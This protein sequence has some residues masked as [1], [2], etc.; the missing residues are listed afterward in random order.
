MGGTLIQIHVYL[1]TYIY[2]YICGYPYIR[3]TIDINMYTY[4]CIGISVYRRTPIYS[5]SLP[6]S[7]RVTEVT[8]SAETQPQYFYS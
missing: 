1:F 8:G 7:L 5:P 4:I 2:I 3:G 6:L